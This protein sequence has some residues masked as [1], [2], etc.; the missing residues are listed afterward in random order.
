MHEILHTSDGKKGKFSIE[1]DGDVL[2][3][4]TYTWSADKIIIDD[5]EVSKAL[6]GQGVGRLLVQSIVEFA[7]GRGA[8]VLPLCP[9]ARSVMEKEAAFGD[10]L[11]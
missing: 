5:T 2:A 4:L 9:F 11:F 7:R 8:K 1:K 6:K 3:Q 10:V